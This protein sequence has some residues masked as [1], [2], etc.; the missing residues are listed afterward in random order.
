MSALNTKQHLAYIEAM[1]AHSKAQAEEAAVR[2]TWYTHWGEACVTP[3][4]QALST[5]R[6]LGAALALQQLHLGVSYAKVE[7]AAMA[8]RVANDLLAL[9]QVLSDTP[10]DLQGGAPDAG[11]AP[12]VGKE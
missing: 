8:L 9:A 12:G 6:E 7:Q 11:L 3:T 1:I 4:P 2:A 5:L 10:E